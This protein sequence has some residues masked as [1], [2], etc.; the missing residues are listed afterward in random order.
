MNNL[1]IIIDLDGTLKTDAYDDGPFELETHEVSTSRNSY[2]F[3]IRPHVK[4]FLSEAQNKGK[5][6]LG[7]A[8]GGNYAGKVLKEMEIFDYFDRIIAAEDFARGIPFFPNFILIENDSD[9]GIKKIDRMG[10]STIKPIRQDLWTI[11]TFQGNPDDTAMLELIQE[12]RK[13]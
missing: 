8:A 2:K 13:L 11:N 1:V 7:T 10:K 3:A 12:I 6:Y 4:T 9:M 5:L